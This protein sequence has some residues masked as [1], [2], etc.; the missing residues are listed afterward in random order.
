MKQAAY[1][2][3]LRESANVWILARFV[4]FAAVRPAIKKRI[5]IPTH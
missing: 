3:E 4:N 1:F 2:A 5:S